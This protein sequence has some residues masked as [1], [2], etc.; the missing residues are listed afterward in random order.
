MEE[1]VA[2][3]V[4]LRLRPPAREVLA[5]WLATVAP[6]AER[7]R[8]VSSLSTTEQS[9]LLTQVPVRS[10]SSVARGGREVRADRVVPRV[11]RGLPAPAEGL[12]PAVPQ[13]HRHMSVAL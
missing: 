3:A 8:E 6:V 7:T 2:L 11:Q 5:V 10:R 1:Q 13:E 12:V 4:A 9:F